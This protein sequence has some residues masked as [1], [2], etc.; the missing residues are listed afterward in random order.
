MAKFKH[1]FISFI[2]LILV[3]IAAVS[4]YGYW[5]IGVLEGGRAFKVPYVMVPLL[6]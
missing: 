3:A 2:A 1:V 6:W 4:I 5:F